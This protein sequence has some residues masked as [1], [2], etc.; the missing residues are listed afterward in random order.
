MDALTPLSGLLENLAERL[1]A[2]EAHLGIVGAAPAASGSAAAA[3]KKKA[4]EPLSPVVVAWD[5]LVTQHLTPFS[6]AAAAIGDKAVDL[7]R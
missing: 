3:P 2:I 7:V 4:E 5:A 1:A 6:N